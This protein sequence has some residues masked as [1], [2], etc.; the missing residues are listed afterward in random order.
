[1]S[2]SRMLAGTAVAALLATVLT[3]PIVRADDE[4][5][6]GLADTAELSYVATSG[7]AE[8]TTLGLKNTLSYTW[9]KARFQLDLGA[10]R[11]ETTSIGRG[12]V[13]TGPAD[14]RLTESKTTQV[15]AESYLL[16]GRYD[17]DLGHGLY[18]FGGAGWE[19]NEPA[20]IQDRFSAVGGIG[21]VWFD[22]KAARFKTDAGLT[23]TDQQDVVRNPAVDEKFLGVRLGYDYWR[24]LTASTAYASVLLVDLN[25]D[26][27]DDYRADFTNSLSV[28]MSERLALKASLQLLYDH[29]PGL[30]AVPIVRPDGSATGS[31]ATAELDDLDSI[32]SVALVAS[33]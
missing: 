6:L 2:R 17:H 9:P 5:K 31:F 3:T 24:Q 19:R 28:A 16:R 29:Q 32:F 11:A 8:A 12:A 13:G 4:K 33:F 30:V 23:Y 18:W 10:L 15:S 1:M 14:F 25:A 27:M 7:N 20:G 22:T 21:K 26:E